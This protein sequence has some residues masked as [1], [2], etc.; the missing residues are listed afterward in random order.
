MNGAERAESRACSKRKMGTS[1]GV[2]WTWWKLKR[3]TS[4]W[5]METLN[6][7]ARNTGLSK[8]SEFESSPVDANDP[9]SLILKPHKLV[10]RI[11]AFFKPDIILSDHS[12][13][14]RLLDN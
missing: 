12:Q 2:E 5:S 7:L 6:S 1:P 14:I 13:Q 11:K 9:A 4:C 3:W 8:A 10:C